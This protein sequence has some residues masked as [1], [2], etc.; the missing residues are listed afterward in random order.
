MQLNTKASVPPIVTHEG[1]RAARIGPLAQLRRSVMA[2]LLWEDEFYEDGV[3]IAQRIADAVKL[4]DPTDAMDVAIEARQRFK[5]RHVPLLIAREMARASP[6]HRLLVGHTLEQVIDRPDELSE[7]LAI[8]WK[9]GR[10]PLAW[11]VKQG[12]KRAFA[13]FNEYSLAKYDRDGAVKLRDV[14]FLVHG[15][16]ADA[17]GPGKKAPAIARPGYSRG[18]T[19]RH[20]ASVYT[21]LVEGTLATPDTWEVALSAGAD[22]RSTFERLI[23]EGRLGAL[24][25]LRNLRNMRQAGVEKPVV[26]QALLEMRA[27]RVL[28]FRFVAAA[29][30]VPEWE[31]AI[32]PAML[33]CLETAPRL[34]GKTVL[35]VD[36]SGSMDGA[37][38]ARSDLAR[39]DAACGLAILLREVCEDVA[40]ATFSNAIAAVP[41]RRGFALRDAIVRSQPHQGT[42][43]GRAVEVLNQTMPYARIIAITDEQAHDDV[44]KPVGAGY[45]INVASAKNGVGYGAWDHI[46]GWS[47]AVIDY[48]REIENVV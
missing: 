2:C 40:I 37:I 9:D 10:Q 36:V 20:V 19:R 32:E 3:A 39:L 29:R 31:D 23:A 48:V 18:E 15:K 38:S 4:C 8:Y 16:P 44:P 11:Q 47:E 12:L 1:G 21:R 35:L 33:R 26:A 27:D 14:L 42:Y 7:F 28:P 22:K 6:A 13:K 30:A 43:L 25:L 17:K 34:A 45:M 24:A 41:P 5:L 46:D